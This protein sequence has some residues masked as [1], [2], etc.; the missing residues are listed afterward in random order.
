MMKVKEHVAAGQQ[1]LTKEDYTAAVYHFTLALKIDPQHKE[2][3]DGKAKA[4][5][6]LG[7]KQIENQDWSLAEVYWKEA[8]QLALDNVDI[9]KM[10]AFVRQQKYLLKKKSEITSELPETYPK[11]PIRIDNLVFQGGGIKGLAYLGA[12][13]ALSK[14][15]DLSKVKRF[16]G[17][18][19]GAINALLLGLG[20]SQKE[21]QILL[22]EVNFKEILMDGDFKD[23]LLSLNARAQQIKAKGADVADKFKR[24]SQASKNP[25]GAVS[26]ASELSQVSNDPDFKMIKEALQ[27]LTQQDFGLFPGE[28]FREE[29]IE[30]LIQAK[31]SIAY[32]TFQELINQGFKPI[33]F[34]GTNI[35]TGNAEVFSHET[36]P[37]AIVSDALRISMSIPLVFKP[38][39]LYI[40]QNGQ[41]VP[42]SS[43]AW[44]VDGGLLDNYPLWLFDKAGYW[45]TAPLLPQALARNPYTLGL[46]LTTAE[47]KAV[48]EGS[49]MEKN[50]PPTSLGSFLWS[51]VQAVYEKQNSDHVKF[52]EQDRSIYIDY[53]G[54]Q[55][56][57][58]DLEEKDQQAL[59]QSGYAAVQ[60]YFQK[61]LA[62][63]TEKTPLDKALEAGNK[64]LLLS[65][66]AQGAYACQYPDQVI[67]LL[68]EAVKSEW[69]DR[70]Q[71]LKDLS[72]FEA[73]HQHILQ[74]QQ[75]SPLMF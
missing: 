47:H 48:Y 14:N 63:S 23:K 29:W 27:L 31:T 64:P 50:P 43:G 39:Q 24:V 54:I 58:F 73:Y 41:R 70:H 7:K 21:L 61:R 56:T 62:P 44:Y 36:T 12:L 74:S 9:V 18:S 75:Y 3:R 34:V 55:T 32:V 6:A 8:H 69:I 26:A 17:T 68:K 42:H 72:H 52:Q 22:K 35:A 51:I 38:H 46:R 33:Y 45:Q 57:Q 25:C 30:P 10:L 71:V 13:E 19:A 49:A 66:I 4:L 5:T 28:Y 16:G 60:H 15:I 11:V 53:L 2:S 20:Y 67:S 40:K 59:M 65:L 37:D 1:K